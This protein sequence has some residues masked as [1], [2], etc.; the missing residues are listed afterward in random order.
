MDDQKRVRE[1]LKQLRHNEAFNQ[2]RDIVAKPIIEQLE[3][4]LAQKCLELP[5]ATLKAKVLYINLLKEL[6]FNIFDNK[7]L[8]D[9]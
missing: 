6:F 2:W 3:I 1:L 9:D 8:L 4:D 5:E 7:A